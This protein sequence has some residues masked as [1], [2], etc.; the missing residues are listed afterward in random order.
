MAGDAD[1]IGR[2]D[3]RETV[4]QTTNREGVHADVGSAK[5]MHSPLFT[6]RH[7]GSQLSKEALPGVGIKAPLT[8]AVTWSSLKLTV[9]EN[10]CRMGMARRSTRCVRP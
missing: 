9:Q 3:G 6:R 8:Y 4:S 5:P 2:A 10:N 1:F 7:K